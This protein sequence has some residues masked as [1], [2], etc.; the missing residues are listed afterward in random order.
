MRQVQEA[1]AK[2]RARVKER[3]AEVK[4]AV[5]D[6][7]ENVSDMV[8]DAMDDVRGYLGIERV[9]ENLQAMKRRTQFLRRIVL[10]GLVGAAMLS[11]GMHFSHLVVCKTKKNMFDEDPKY[12]R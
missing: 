4:E 5:M 8:E 2:V 1:R 12:T 9:E 6:L 11:Y 7:H 10:K 3:A